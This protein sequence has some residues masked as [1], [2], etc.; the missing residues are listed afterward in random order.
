MWAL[1]LNSTVSG[2]EKWDPAA[3]SLLCCFKK[4]KATS[5]VEHDA[6]NLYKQFIWA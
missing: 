5:L 6:H 2:E 3:V 4:Q 1:M